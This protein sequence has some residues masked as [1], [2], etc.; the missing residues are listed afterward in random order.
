MYSIFILGAGFSRPARMPLGYELFKEVLEMAMDIDLYENILRRDVEQFLG[1][2]NKL[3]NSSI[4]EDEIS[5]EE[6]I[7]YLDIEHYLALRGSDT[8]SSEGNRSQILIRNLIAK[9]LFEKVSSMNEKD[10]DLYRSFVDNMDPGDIIIT[11]NYDTIIEES[12]ERENKP[13]RLF[14]ERFS[15]VNHHSGIRDSADQE[16][17]LLK[18]HGS[19]DWFDIERFDMSYDYFRQEKFFK[20]PEHVIFRNRSIFSPMKII[21]GPYSADSLL[22]RIY[23]VKNLGKYFEERD[24]V[25]QAPLILSPSFNKIVYLNPLKEFWYSFY[26]AGLLNQK[27]AVIGFSLP[28]HDDYIRQALF[29]LV[30]NFQVFD[31]GTTDLEKSKLKIVDY[32]KNESEIQEFKNRYSFIDWDNTDC[33]F[34]GFDKEAIEMIFESES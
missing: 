32:R 34:D 24:F 12:L 11:F 30:N 33:Y 3:N 28:E 4:T 23:R 10:F 13:Y 19:I 29:T 5:F 9:V 26:D 14:L 18:M 25:R 2:Y 1:Y 6:F 27:V 21:D 15:S 8:W 7:S 20:L 31:P 17:I 22:N 16:V